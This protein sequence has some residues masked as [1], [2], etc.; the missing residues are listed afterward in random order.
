MKISTSALPVDALLQKYSRPSARAGEVYYTDCYQ[1]SE[2]GRIALNDYVYAFYTSWLF[3]L[4]RW[5]LEHLVHKPSTDEEAR[6]LADGL[7]AD[8]AAWH[9]EVRTPTQLMMCDFL[10]RT[11]SWLMV[12]EVTDTNPP[13][14]LLRFGSAVVPGGDKGA[15][16]AGLAYRLL[17]PFHRIYSRL[18]LRAAISQLRRQASDGCQ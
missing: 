13:H 16:G 9:V 14:T 11:R 18:L 5:I 10:G 4:E 2:P 3:R 12:E 15:A 8:F 7:I 6:K 17:L 1:A